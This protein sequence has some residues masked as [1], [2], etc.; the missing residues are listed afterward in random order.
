[1][2]GWDRYR[3]HINRARTHYTELLFSHLVGY[4]GLVVHSGVSG[5]RNINALFF[6]LGWDQYELHKS[7]LEHVTLNMCFRIWWDLS[8]T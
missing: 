4:A 3:F 2:L 5:P 1:M 6:T 8:V 7:V